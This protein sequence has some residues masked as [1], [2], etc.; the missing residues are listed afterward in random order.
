MSAGRKAVS[1]ADLQG[2]AEGGFLTSVRKMLLGEDAP[3]GPAEDEPLTSR[4]LAAADVDWDAYGKPADWAHRTTPA[5]VRRLASDLACE[6]LP[7]RDEALVRKM[8]QRWE[9]PENYSFSRP[10]VERVQAMLQR[11]YKEVLRELPQAPARNRQPV[12][13]PV[14][15]SHYG[16]NSRVVTRRRDGVAFV[17]GYVVDEAT[18]QETLRTVG[19]S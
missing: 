10:D 7:V 4:A 12:K 14:R 1:L 5:D 17:G 16:A 2:V 19:E 15:Q 9:L 13:M 18:A 11:C 3:G 8:A 6:R